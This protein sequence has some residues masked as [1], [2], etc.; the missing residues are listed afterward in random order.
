[1]M[2]VVPH[3]P[4]A[5]R[6]RSVFNK[7]PL[8]CHPLKQYCVHPLGVSGMISLFSTEEGENPS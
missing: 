5:L 4:M 6:I 3:P 8:I 2:S 1:M 7:C